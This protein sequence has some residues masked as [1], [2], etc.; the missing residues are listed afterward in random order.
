MLV[1]I[2]VLEP[3]LH[4]PLG[5]VD[6][7]GNSFSNKGGR[8]RILVELY[9]KQD[10]L[11]LCCPLPLLVLL[12]LSESTFAWWTAGVGKIRDGRVHG[13]YA[14]RR[15]ARCSLHLWRLGLRRLE[16]VGAAVHRE[17]QRWFV[18]E[19][20]VRQWIRDVVEK[21]RQWEYAVGNVSLSLIIRS[22][23]LIACERYSLAVRDRAD[24]DIMFAKERYGGQRSV[25]C[26]KGKQW[27]ES[28]SRRCPD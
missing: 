9:F 23:S 8:C 16:R 21:G 1:D 17:G 12:L 14:W 20:D 3:D 24:R 7:L 4:G 18:N 22:M 2:P 11:I 13:Q 25:S 10:K 26:Q 5:H 6:V 28:R 19:M 15:C 27:A